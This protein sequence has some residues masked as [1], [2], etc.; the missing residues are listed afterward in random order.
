MTICQEIEGFIEVVMK[1]FDRHMGQ[2]PNYSRKL[3]LRKFS[4]EYG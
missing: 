3:I 4:R 1:Y 2:R